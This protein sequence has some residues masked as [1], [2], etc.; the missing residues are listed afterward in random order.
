M[1]QD[2]T[3]KEESKKKSLESKACLYPLMRAHW[4]RKVDHM[5]IKFDLE[6]K[7]FYKIMRAG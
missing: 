1:K 5:K 2:N 3:L 4:F 7:L 6:S